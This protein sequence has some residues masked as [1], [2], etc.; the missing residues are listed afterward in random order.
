[1]RI[2]SHAT[3]FLLKRH[4]LVRFS[5]GVGY[6]LTVLLFFS[7]CQ[8]DPKKTKVLRFRQFEITVPGNWHRYTWELADAEMNGITNEIDSIWYEY[9]AMTKTPFF[10]FKTE[11]QLYAAD[12]VNGLPAYIS[13]PDSGKVGFTRLLI[14]NIIE[15]YEFR[16]SGYDI[17]DTKSALKIFKSVMVAGSDATK[18]PELTLKNFSTIV[19]AEA[20]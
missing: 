4:L 14:P 2:I 8:G 6:L 5:G 18:N 19:P 11:G 17:K 20:Y 7:D 12:T 13:I 15:G 1:M 3:K 9:N 16:M 10:L